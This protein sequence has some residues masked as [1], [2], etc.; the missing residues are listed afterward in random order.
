M[1]ESLEY[2]RLYEPVGFHDIRI[3]R[4]FNLGGSNNNEIRIRMSVRNSNRDAI[5]ETNK[6]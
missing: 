6:V 4:L 5:Y 1:N 2:V 3:L